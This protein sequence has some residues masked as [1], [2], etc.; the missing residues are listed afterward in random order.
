MNEQDQVI[1]PSSTANFVVKSYISSKSPLY[2]FFNWDLTGNHVFS[3]QFEE[4]ERGKNVCGRGQIQ[5]K[6]KLGS[7]SKEF[8]SARKCF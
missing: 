1:L 2:Y 3:G 5:K 8:R 7:K 4:G 6:I